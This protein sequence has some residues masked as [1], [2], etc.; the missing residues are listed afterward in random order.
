MINKLLDYIGKILISL[1]LLLLCIIMI[2]G[3][4]Y[5]ALEIIAKL[6]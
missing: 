2:Q 1:V 3:I 5:L 4:V 6:I